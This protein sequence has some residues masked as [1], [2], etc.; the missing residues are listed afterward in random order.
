MTRSLRCL[1]ALALLVTAGCAR[2]V[3]DQPPSGSVPVFGA[4]EL[5][6]QLA[7]V[8][9]FRG[10]ADF[11]DVPAVSVYGDGRVITLGPQIEIY[12]PPALPN[13]QV[14]TIK[15]ADL[16]RLLDRARAA[17]IGEERDFGQPGIADATTARFRLRTSEGLV[18]TEVYAL[19]ESGDASGLTEEQQA[20][21]RGP[22]QLM[23]TMQDLR[24]T[25]GADA[26]G[27][28]RPYQAKAVAAVARE[29][30][31][32]PQMPQKEIAWPGPDLP[33]PR[34]SDTPWGCVT[35]TGTQA[36]AIYAA[37]AQANTLTPWVSGGKRW[38]AQLRPLLPDEVNCMSI[39][40]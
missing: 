40:G 9:G 15:Q 16:Q 31:A 17:R 13:V 2:Q 1:L 18:Q 37:A 4:D 38:F 3:S 5:V 19:T 22:A 20:N 39:T 14:A 7:F 26:V 32:D 34:I 30:T 24:K 25:F 23:Q 35:A 29:W 8:G 6:L 11:G 21:R 28:E 10:D 33:G 27:P 12:P 36:E